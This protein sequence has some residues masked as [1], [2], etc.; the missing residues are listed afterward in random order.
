MPAT[1][2]PQKRIPTLGA[3]HSLPEV[4]RL[5]KLRPG[6]G[7]ASRELQRNQLVEPAEADD[8]ALDQRAF[9]KHR[10][11]P[12]YLKGPTWHGPSEDATRACTMRG[13]TSPSKSVASVIAQARQEQQRHWH[14]QKFLGY[15]RMTSPR[16]VV[17]CSPEEKM[18]QRVIKQKINLAQA[19]KISTAIG[20]WR[21]PPDRSSRP[22]RSSTF[23]RPE[24]T[25]NKPWPPI[26]NN[27]PV[28][29]AARLANGASR[30]KKEYKGP[31][32]MPDDVSARVLR[33]GPL[34]SAPKVYSKANGRRGDGAEEEKPG[35]WAR[36]RQIQRSV[37]AMQI[38][39]KERG[40]REYFRNDPD[41][42]FDE[43]QR[44]A[45]VQLWDAIPAQKEL[46]RSESTPAPVILPEMLDRPQLSPNLNDTLRP[47]ER[48]E[49]LSGLAA[50]EP[51]LSLPSSSLSTRAAATNPP[52]LSGTSTNEQHAVLGIEPEKKPAAPPSD[53]AAAD[54]MS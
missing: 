50:G 25:V 21:Y 43:D 11:P 46:V 13:S 34:P 10:R 35:L 17:K 12:P 47:P 15:A 33:S 28:L 44:E 36:Q 6:L 4:T 40:W 20:V 37:T 32:K 53:E 31:W 24:Q 51:R 3:S 41:E 18:R 48:D 22:S 42:L 26:A 9:G 52:P 7:A 38:L 29:V 8:D 2:V 39:Y 1:K 14:A 54:R 23:E 30:A 49:E 27:N 16:I 45:L 19:Q 5:T